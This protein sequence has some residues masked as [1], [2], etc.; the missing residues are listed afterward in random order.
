MRIDANCTHIHVAHVVR[1]MHFE[2]ACQNM[3]TCKSGNENE[4][5]AL[6]KSLSVSRVFPVNYGRRLS[7]IPSYT[8]ARARPVVV[9]PHQSTSCKKVPLTVRTEARV[10]GLSRPCR[11]RRVGIAT[12]RLAS[13]RCIGAM[14][15]AGNMRIP[16]CGGKHW[17][18]LRMVPKLVPKYTISACFW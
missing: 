13:K 16:K 5:A 15:A 1:A 17:P 10:P 14:L 2:P 11:H 6:Q 9:T 7:P 12:R 3:W 4:L 8:L 18:A